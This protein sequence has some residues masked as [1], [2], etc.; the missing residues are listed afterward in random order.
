MEKRVEKGKLV[1]FILSEQ[2]YQQLTRQVQKSTC[3][4][5]SEYIR[6]KLLDKS[7]VYQQRNRSLDDFTEAL[8]QIKEE[9]KAAVYHFELAVRRLGLIRNAPEIAHRLISF[10]LDKR[11]LLKQVDK[12]TEYFKTSIEKWS[13]ESAPQDNSNM[14]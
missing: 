7:L 13:Q 14:L 6:K 5:Q 4:S 11:M 2:D 9:L 1:R 10:E 8:T 3:R 12:T